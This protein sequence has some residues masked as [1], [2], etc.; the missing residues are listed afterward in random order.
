MRNRSSLAA[1]LLLLVL[2]VVTGSSLAQPSSS[3][4]L[5]FERLPT[6]WDEALPLGN[7]KLG[8]LVWKNGTALRFSLDQAELWDLRPMEGLRRPDVSFQW[9]KEQLLANNY[10]AVQQWGDAPYDREPA[11]SKI[12]GAA[13]EWDSQAW[14]EVTE[15]KVNLLEAVATVAWASGVRLTTYV[16]ATM[17][18]G[19]FRFENLAEFTPE[20]VAPRYAGSGNLTQGGPVEGDD[21][22]R[23]GYEQGQVE[24][25]PQSLTYRQEGWGDFFYV[26]SVRWQQLAPATWE[27]VWSISAHLPDKTAT[28][29][30]L[31][32]QNA[33]KLSSATLFKEHQQWWSTFWGKSSLRVPDQLLERQYYLD[34]YKWGS[35]ARADAPPIS[36]QA[37]WTAD[38]GRIPPWKGDYHHDL[39]TQLS[40]WPAYTGNRL[41]EAMGY[42]NHL[43][44]NRETYEDYT[45]WYFNVGGLN[46]P[47]VTTLTGQEMGGWIQY[48]LSPTVSAWLAQHYYLHWRY[49]MDR[50]FLEE[51]AYPWIRDV[52]TFLE[53]LTDED[54]KGKRQLP[55]SSSPEIFDNSAKAWFRETTNYDLSL[56]RFVFAKAAEL[57]KEL[58]LT[59]EAENWQS[60]LDELPTYA[61]SPKN[62]LMIA[63]KFPYTASHRHLSHLM[64]IHPLGEIRW[65]NG[66]KDRQIIKNSLAQ[67][68]KVGPSQ[69]TGYSYAWQ[70]NL[71]ARAKDGQG[72]ATALRTFAEAF[73]STN[74]FHV[75][76]DQSGTGKSSFTYRPFTLEGNFAFAAGVQEMLLQSYAGFIELFPAVPA[77]W[78]EASFTSLRT[79]G[80]FLVSAQR[81]QG[82]LA[83][84]TVEATEAGTALLKVPQTYQVKSR[85]GVTVG[86][87]GDLLELK[88]TKGGR[89]ELDFP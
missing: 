18:Y 20:L 44:E 73:C 3:H 11:P 74:S 50:T 45:Q 41:E 30:T 75:N 61:L 37:I 28:R 2:C 5:A 25:Q 67:L 57:A 27:G 23:L 64:A 34:L 56:M 76:G 62:E 79:E 7:A 10:K 26:V 59:E 33:L 69:W 49:S 68:D 47:G 84:A 70:G 43:D 35:T 83:T 87:N 72:A 14:G 6:R 80:A 16:H 22:R 38:N 86:H 40:Y 81:K 15:A 17:P 42:L 78:Q 24:R 48:S 19:Y 54:A 9:V 51:R 13:L 46:V 55:L 21:L 1:Q 53:E 63:P 85:R 58:D 4:D 36:L 39:N 60:L 31:I 88:F 89:V 66:E 52:A 65:E 71:K 12:P 77:S 32:T 8:T 82:R 29:A